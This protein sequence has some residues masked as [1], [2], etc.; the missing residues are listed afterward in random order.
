MLK[1]GDKFTDDEVDVM[2]KGIPVDANGHFNYRDFVR[3]L[4][5]AE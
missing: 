4:K 3:V 2:F 1:M 5:N